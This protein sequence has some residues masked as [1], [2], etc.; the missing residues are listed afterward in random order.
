M[1][2]AMTDKLQWLEVQ[3]HRVLYINFKGLQEKEQDELLD[4]IEAE[5]S[6]HPPGTLL[7]ITDI[8]G[9]FGTEKGVNRMKE[10]GKKNPSKYFAAVGVTG[11]KKILGKM[12]KKDMYFAEDLED[13]KRWIVKKM[14]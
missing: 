13:A 12:I 14:V 6:K 3:G 9:S 8:T 7:V 4:Q 5:Y 1:G 10:I 11:V 2:F